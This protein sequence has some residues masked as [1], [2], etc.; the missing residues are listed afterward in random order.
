MTFL[1]SLNPMTSEIISGDKGIFNTRIS[2][3]CFPLVLIYITLLYYCLPFRIP[4][5][6]RLKTAQAHTLVATTTPLTNP[7]IYMHSFSYLSSSIEPHTN[8]TL[9][10]LQSL[11]ATRLNHVYV[12]S[13]HH[14]QKSRC[15]ILCLAGNRYWKYSMRILMWDSS[16]EFREISVAFYI[17]PLAQG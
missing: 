12:L 8:V 5:A 17:S 6:L 2:L 15:W 3:F 7:F 11:S 13:T 16:V 14:L 10:N 4:S 9:D 1:L